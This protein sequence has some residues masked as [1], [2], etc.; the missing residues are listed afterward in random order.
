MLTELCAE[1]RNWF[2]RA[3]D[4]HSGTFT[5]SGGVIA[6]SDFIQ[7]GQYFRIIGS[8]FNDGVHQFPATDL[9]DESFTG[10]VWAMAVPPAVIALDA[11]IEAYCK[12]EGA[13]SA[14]TSESFGSYSYSKATDS[15]GAPASWQVVFKQ[16]LGL[17]RKLR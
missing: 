9:Q 14:L 17:W 4:K 12:A 7:N 10:S 13:P 15:T 16:R 5:I 8:V 11:D 2:T 3:E 6:P 1:I